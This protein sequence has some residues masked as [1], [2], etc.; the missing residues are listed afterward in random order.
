MSIAWEILLTSF[1]RHEH[2]KLFKLSLFWCLSAAENYVLQIFESFSNSTETC[3]L[4]KNVLTNES[5][6]N[7]DAP[8]CFAAA[9]LHTVDSV[10]VCIEAEAQRNAMMS[11]K[12][13]VR[14]T[15]VSSL[16]GGNV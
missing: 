15:G 16:N 7:D 14:R 12:W 9:R 2:K 1:G 6:G 10:D 3:S 11:T 5:T 13:L 8:I 4:A